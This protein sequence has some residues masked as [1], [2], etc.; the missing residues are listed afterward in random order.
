MEYG[1]RRLNQN[2]MKQNENSIFNKSETD[3]HRASC[4]EKT[5]SNPDLHPRITRNRSHS[6]DLFGFQ[7]KSDETSVFSPTNYEKSSYP[8]D[9]ERKVNLIN[10]KKDGSYF[11]NRLEYLIK[12]M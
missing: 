10:G 12:K 7:I 6:T 1:K 4:S 9:M 11:K 8:D 5:V 2:S 3:S